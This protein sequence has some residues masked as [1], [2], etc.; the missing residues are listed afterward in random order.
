MGMLRACRILYIVPAVQMS[1]CNHVM[2]L[3]VVTTWKGLNRSLYE[4][5]SRTGVL[6]GTQKA[7]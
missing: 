5:Q 3:G 4:L 1:P 2:L 6:S 7:P